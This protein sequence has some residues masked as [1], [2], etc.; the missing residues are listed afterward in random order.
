MKKYCSVFMKTLAVSF[1][2]KSNLYLTL[3]S[4][5]IFTLVQFSLWYS[6]YDANN[7]I[8]KIEFSLVISYIF[9]GVFVRILTTVNV[10]D[11]ISEQINKGNIELSLIR[12]YNFFIFCFSRHFSTII[13]DFCVRGIFLFVICSLLFNKYIQI[14]S[15]LINYTF[16]A[17]SLLIAI[18]LS[19]CMDYL[20]GLLSFWVIH[21]WQIKFL[22]RDIGNILSGFF[23]PLWMFPAFLLKI[24]EFLPFKYMFFIPINILLGEYSLNQIYE[25]LLLGFLW[26]V[27]FLVSIVV[28]SIKLQKRIFIQGG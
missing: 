22:V 13:A 12:P 1:A 24:S 16:F 15:S 20:I 18:F 25:E 28:L 3:I 27:I 17:I 10:S 11:Y 14:E 26:V 7:S 5:I 8:N 21:T 2:Y 4:T 6:I 9:I 19:Y 23:V